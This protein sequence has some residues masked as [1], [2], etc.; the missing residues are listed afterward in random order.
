MAK[1]KKVLVVGGGGR[2]HAIVD[3]LGRSPQVAK[4]YCAPG[5]AGIALQAECVPLNDTDVDGLLAFAQREGI[6]LTVVGPEAALA[7]GIVDAFRAAGLRIFGHTQAATRIESSKEFAK[8][9]MEKYGVPTAG[10]RSFS[11]FR[12]ALDY[13]NARPFPA[14]LKYDGLA[15]GKGVVIAAKPEEAEAALRSMLQDGEFGTGRVVVEDFLTGPEFSFMAF[16]DGE[17]VYPMPLAQDHKRAFD[18]DRGPNTG[19]MGAY[20][21]LPFI[22]DEDRTFALERILQ[23]TARAMCAEGCPLSGVLYGGLM[24]TPDGIKVIE[25]NARFG[26][27]ETEVVL[28]LLASDI[29]EVFEAVACGRAAAQPVWRDAVTLGV[30]LASKGYPG[31]YEKGA[32]IR[33]TEAVDA[34]IYH[35]GTRRDGDRLLTAGGRVMMVVAEGADIR[36]AQQKVYAEVAKISCDALFCRRDIA[37]GA[38]DG[39][40]LDGKALSDRIKEDLRERVGKLE[41]KYGRKPSLAVIIVG[42]NPASQVY[43]RNKVK[44]AIYVGMNSRLITMA[45]DAT[46]QAL[47]EM[48]GTLNRDPEVDG[49][50]V[51]LPLPKQ[52]DEARVIDAIDKGKDVDGFHVLNVGDLWLGRPCSVPCTPKGILRLIDESGIDLCGKTAVVVGRSN[53]VGKPVA[54]LLLDRNATV[55]VAHSRTKDLRRVTLQ[56]D[57][58]VVAVGRENVVTG[59]MVKPGAVVIDVGMNRNAAGRL[60]GDVDFVGARQQ[61]SW[62]TPVPGGVGPMTIAMLLE[63]TVECFLARVEKNE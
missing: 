8:Q 33:G 35:M 58:L 10:Y 16:V 59:D 47:L 23:T 15:A 39:R 29:Y 31:A 26:D 55:I 56:A 44:S 51:Q 48:I 60:C 62:I 45:E 2:C 34:K 49:I 52:I 17:R 11:D 37:H 21:G 53:I 13:V 43:V 57:V 27:P 36:S 40:L 25:F 12:E 20:T 28:P 6:D 50:L 18:G 54:K 9:L 46:E 30:V 61:A 4:I 5:N 14:V 22:T 42:N 41:V 7:V 38:L 24:K 3:A 63:N 19:G 1:D 32:E